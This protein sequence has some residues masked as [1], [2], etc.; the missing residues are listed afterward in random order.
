MRRTQKQY[1]TDILDAI[2]H[3][4]S[5]ING[6]GLDDLE[7][8]VRT[9]WALERAFGIIGEAAK[10]IDPELKS[11]YPDLPWRDISGM[12]DFLVHGYWMVKLEIIVDTIQIDF[13]KHKPI[14]EQILSY[15]QEV[16]IKNSSE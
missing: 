15:L 2:S 16:E 13:P 1:I 14:F 5:F 6:L 9:Q 4:E 10:K 11:Q 7:K 8:D 12:R 3:A